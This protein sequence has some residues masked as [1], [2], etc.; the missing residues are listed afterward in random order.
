MKF[1]FYSNETA[2][3]SDIENANRLFDR[4]YDGTD[5]V[6]VLS[7]II[8]DIK[9]YDIFDFLARLSALNLI[10]ENQNKSTLLDPVIG[11]LLAAPRSNYSSLI[12][13]SNGK[14]RKIINRIENLSLAMK[15][16]PAE[17]A[18]IE[19]VLFYDNY[20]IFPGINYSP[21]YTLQGFIKALFLKE[22][23]F[24]YEFKSKAQRLIHFVLIISNLIAEKLNYGIHSLEHI[25][26][27]HIIIPSSDR[28]K[29]LVRCVVIE[30]DHIRLLLDYDDKLFNNLYCEFGRGNIHDIIFEETQT[31]FSHPFL[32][33]NETESLILNPSILVPYVIHQIV[34][35][36]E[37]YNIKF[38][39]IDAY[40][41]VIW[42]N[43]LSSLSQLGHHKIVEKE[44]GIELYHGKN[45]KEVILNVENDQLLVL[46]YICDDGQGYG[47]ET[48]FGEYPR[49]AISNI[50]CQRVDYLSTRLGS[51]PGV[52]QLLIIN[53]FGRHI[54]TAIKQIKEHT[55]VSLSPFELACIAINERNQDAFLPR[56]ICS[57]D[58]I[59][60]QPSVVISELNSIETYISNDYSFY[61][62]DEFSPKAGILFF[63]PGDSLDYVIRAINQEDRQLIDSYNDSYLEEVIL[64][65]K[66]RGIYVETAF[67][68]PRAAL[69]VKISNVIIWIY[70]P[71]ILNHKDLNI[72]FSIVDAISFWIAECKEAIKDMAFQNQII[73]LCVRLSGNTDDYNVAVEVHK[74]FSETVTFEIDKNV[75]NIIWTPDSLHLLCAKSNEIEKQ[76]MICI[77]SRFQ[78]LA[79]FGIINWTLIDTVFGNSLKKKFFM[80]EYTTT[81]YFKPVNPRH[82]CKVRSEDENALLDDVGSY[83]LATGKWAYG[84]VRDEERA[85]VANSV[86][87]YFYA[88][89]KEIVANINPDHFYELVCYDLEINIYYMMLAQARY[90]YDIA[91][92]PEKVAKFQKDFN[93]LNRSSRALRFLAEYI[94]ACPPS[95]EQ[96]L[97]KMQYEKILAICSLIIEWAYRND[98]FYYHIFKTPVEFL[99]SGRI[100][101]KQDEND[102]LTRINLAARTK[103]LER[104]SNPDIDQFF[105]N[106]ILPDLQAKVDEAYFEEY[107]YSFAQF[108]SCVFNLI[109]HG[110]Q[111]EGEVKRVK[112]KELIQYIAQTDENLDEKI[113]GQII[114]NISLV[115][116][117]DFLKPPSPYR[118][119]D[120]YPWRFNRELSFTRRP[121][122]VKGDMVIWGNRQLYHMWTFLIDLIIEGKLKAHS[123]R[124]TALIGELSNKRGDEFNDRVLQKLKAISGLI[125]RD[126]VS[127]V[128]K[129]RICD[130]NG[131]TLGDI[132][133]LYVV[134][135]LKKIVVAEVKEFSFAKNPYEMDQ[136]YQRMFVDKNGKLS[137]ASKH[138][139]RIKWISDH[140]DDVK[141][142]FELAGNGWSIKGIF[143][144]SKEIISNAFYKAG[145]TIITYSEMTEKNI[146]SV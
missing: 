55:L 43:C 99:P 2:Y 74:D 102:T 118:K 49:Q 61:I 59:N 14:F 44:L 57:K 38:D 116:R 129:K 13:M 87:N 16:D 35:M 60:Q 104:H 31:F 110:D 62:S 4:L 141:A 101:M 140:I 94:S 27:N 108:T 89:L 91:C 139:R 125:V 84:I 39:V 28:L 75:L 11:A 19:R 82:F 63:T 33:I 98:L 22:N 21:A 85:T 17:N 122:M 105:P 40:N 64:N 95:G 41:N 34:L 6:K 68:V 132:D 53:S 24:D 30:T 9:A 146:K 127:K 50:I 51:I 76:M 121:L 66:N 7:E 46:H 92:Y 107:G 103:Q 86:V 69:A 23:S 70:S 29:E 111:L 119:E 88:Q 25:E 36:A 20:W 48:L 109:D 79:E 124:L 113:V 71:E 52:Y 54:G 106:G 8:E 15:I 47:N 83:L 115:K 128:N 65:D 81:P 144:V 96:I 3:N 135:E 131:M 97:G 130:T 134:P 112:L 120:I 93:E 90:V 138:N 142:Q 42:K 126:R 1:D 78:D 12:K 77:F 10:L 143:I 123:K 37:E 145:H 100:G 80:L 136:E 67:S 18:F 133:V 72:Y 5:D 58:R 26:T 114:D 73:K 117:D 32:M 45:Y 56:Y 137:Y